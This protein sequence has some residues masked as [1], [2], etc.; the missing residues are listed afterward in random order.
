MIRVVFSEFYRVT[1]KSSF[2]KEKFYFLQGALEFSEIIEELWKC[3]F[4]QLDFVDGL[5]WNSRRM[6]LN[7][8]SV[9]A[10]HHNR[11]E[12]CRHVRCR[13]RT[14]RKSNF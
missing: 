2:S 6:A 12:E 3:F 11:F 9:H 1:R 5:V 4:N 7:G 10:H 8:R 14:T 13:A